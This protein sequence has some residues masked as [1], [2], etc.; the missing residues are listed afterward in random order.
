MKLHRRNVDRVIPIPSWYYVW[1]GEE[2][3][4]WCAL[5]AG[6]NV[7]SQILKITSTSIMAWGYGAYIDGTD[8]V[9][10]P[11]EDVGHPYAKKNCK[12]PCANEAFDG[13]L[14]RQLDEL[15]PTK[16]YPTDVGKDV[17]C[18]HES[19]WEEEPYH[20][21]E[22]VVHDKVGLNDDQ[23]ESHVG[24]GELSKLKSI[25]SFPKRS[26]EENEACPPCE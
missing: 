11:H 10:V 15:C 12:H 3:R 14:G 4:V 7:C 19:S 26:N 1:M 5:K 6:E 24:P 17:V 20:S 13:L 2:N 8:K 25:G 9:R 23:V 16:G 21:L 18:D 22:N